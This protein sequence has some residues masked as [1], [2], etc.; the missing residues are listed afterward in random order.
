MAGNAASTASAGR[1]DCL[2]YYAYATPFGPVTLQQREG[3]LVRLSLGRTVLEGVCRPT[4]LTNRAASQLQEYFAGKRR[5]FD[6]PLQP[7][8]TAFQRQVWEAL[9]RIPYGQTRSYGDVAA[10]IGHAGAARAVGQANNRNPIPIF[11]PCHRVIAADGSLGGYALGPKVKQFL[12][13]LEARYAGSSS[14]GK[15]RTAHVR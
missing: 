12:L 8:G 3:L 14:A 7:Q 1:G 15:G 5:V 11:I 9:V 10:S 6:V 13:A 2:T 4:D